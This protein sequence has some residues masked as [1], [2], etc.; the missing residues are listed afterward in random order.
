MR[1]SRIAALFVGATFLLPPVLAQQ[2]L[3]F[4]YFERHIRPLLAEHCYQCHSVETLA[5]GEFRLDS[6]ENLLRGGSRGPAI[7]PG[8]PDGSLLLKAVSYQSL[9][10]KMPPTGKLSDEQIARLRV[11]IEMGAPDPR[12]AEMQ[13]AVQ[14]GIDIDAGKQFVPRR[15]GQGARLFEPPRGAYFGR[16]RAPATAQQRKA[17]QLGQTLVRVNPALLPDQLRA[18]LL[19]ELPTYLPGVAH[20]SLDIDALVDSIYAS[21]DGDLVPL[22]GD[23][24]PEDSV[25]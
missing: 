12:S 6:K 23:A 24:P 11:W 8:D 18:A 14:E 1:G 5:M 21:H 17:M 10:L 13:E 22:P 19:A 20:E 4:E 25:Q 9:S 3:G 2:P 16:R 15:H 7:H